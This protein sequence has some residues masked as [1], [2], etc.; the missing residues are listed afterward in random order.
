MAIVARR[1]LQRLIRENAG[2]TSREQRKRQAVALDRADDESLSAEWEVLVLNGL[3]KLLQVQHEM[4]L[5]GRRPDILSRLGPAHAPEMF[6]A[7]IATAFESGYHE[8]NPIEAL[9]HE[10]HARA[11]RVGLLGGFHL[12]AEGEMEGEPGKQ[13][14][15]LKVPRKSD[16]PRFFKEVLDPFLIACAR[17]R[18]VSRET[19]ISGEGIELHLSFTPNSKISGMGCPSFT[20]NYSRTRNSIFNILK[21][22]GQQL[23]D[24]GFV[25]ARGV[26]LCA[27]DADLRPSASAGHGLRAITS[28]VFRQN[29]SL[30]FVLTLWSLDPVFE[31]GEYRSELYLN[32]SALHALGPQ[33]VD[34]LTRLHTVLPEPRNGGT[35]ALHEIR[36]WRWKRGRYFYGSWAMTESAVKISVRVLLEYLAGR[37]TREE[38]LDRHGRHQRFVSLFEQKL[39]RGQ[40]LVGAAIKHEPDR[41]DDWIEF[42]FGPPDPALA[43][44]RPE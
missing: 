3:S 30:S 34:A 10:L 24:T 23:R 8:R 14:M 36:F 15:V 21:R 9:N 4:L 26:I 44:L 43:P 7:D 20:T 18:N 31:R 5:G 37:I 42:E 28:E 38:F 13:Q 11:R 19:K 32:P 17:E 29:H 41:D 25:G 16:Q 12:R 39:R 33:A 2:I 6:I 35:N 40:L 22:K 1:V 27:A